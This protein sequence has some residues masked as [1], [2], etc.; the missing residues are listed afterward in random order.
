M[1]PCWILNRNF[2]ISLK[3]MPYATPTLCI[4]QNN[5]SEIAAEVGWKQ[6]IT[7]LIFLPG[8]CSVT[9]IETMMKI[10]LQCIYG[11]TMDALFWY[12][13]KTSSI[14]R[15]K[16]QNSNASCI[17]FQLSWLHP[18]KPGVKLRMKMQ[19]EQRRQAM[20]QL[21]L[22]YQHFYCLLRCDLY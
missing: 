13:R 5:N 6:S 1:A 12:Y 19:L 14:S 8:W 15:T 20:L 22:S 10:D 16:S 2:T 17:L 9:Y 7:G 4:I 11:R 21:H 3:Y 18:L